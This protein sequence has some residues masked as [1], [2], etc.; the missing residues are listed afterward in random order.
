MLDFLFETSSVWTC[1]PSLLSIPAEQPFKVNKALGCNINI[2]AQSACHGLAR[3]SFKSK[4]VTFP[5]L[6]DMS[7]R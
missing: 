7:P 3:S 1:M 2:T 6:A 4:P 5:G